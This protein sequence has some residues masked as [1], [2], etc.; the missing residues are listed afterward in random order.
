MADEDSAQEKTEEP[1]SKRA[2]K[3]REEGQIPR[4]RDLTT[5]AILILGTLGLYLFGDLIGKAMVDV[6]IFNFSVERDVLLD[7]NYMIAHLAKSFQLLLRVIMPLFAV[8]LVAS[9]VGPISLG[10]WNFSSKSLMPKFSRMD[11]LAGIKRMFSAKS[12]V[13]LVKSIA[14]VSLVV[15]TSYLL[16]ILMK[17]ELLGLSAMDPY[18]AMRKSVQLSLWASLVL[19]CSTLVIVII[20]VPFQLW[21]N[22][23]KLKMSLQEVKDEMKDSEGKPEVKSKIRQMQMQASQNRMMAAV[24]EADVVITNPT[25]FSVAL[26]YDPE[27]MRAPILLA[28]GVDHVALRIREVAKLNGVEFVVSPPLARAVY[29][30]T[31]IEQE[32][33]EGLYIAVAQVLAYVFQLREFRKGLGDRPDLPSR[34]DIPTGFEY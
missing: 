14:K 34:P 24:P 17:G 5:S 32:I 7:S 12:I 30:T 21:D 8:L 11:P 13:E 27:N 19:A 1:T 28:K 26:K 15:S 10:G 2:D 9:I 23:K 20:D 18:D 4:S 29:H 16:L 25:H 6:S 3:A 31:E 33:P 22:K